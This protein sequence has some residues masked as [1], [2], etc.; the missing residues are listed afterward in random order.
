MQVGNFLNAQESAEFLDMHKPDFYREWINTGKLKPVMQT[1][2]IKL[3]SIT[4]LK[5]IKK[6]LSK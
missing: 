5:R 4:D 3:Y 1:G 6:L 2:R